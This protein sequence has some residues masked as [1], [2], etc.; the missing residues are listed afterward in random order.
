MKNFIICAVAVICIS[1]KNY[2]LFAQSGWFTVVTSGEI[3]KPFKDIFFSSAD[4]G[5]IFCGQSSEQTS[6]GGQTWVEVPN[7]IM[8]TYPGSSNS[9]QICFNI[10]DF[11]DS[12][13]RSTNNGESWHEYKVDSLFRNNY[14]TYFTFPSESI[15]FIGQG[16]YLF[17]TT[18]SAKTWE[19]NHTFGNNDGYVVLLNFRDAMHGICATYDVGSCAMFFDEYIWRTS[20]GGEHWVSTYKRLFAKD[21]FYQ[22]RF[23]R[24]IAN[25][26][27]GINFSYDDGETWQLIRFPKIVG[28]FEKLTFFNDTIGYA[29]TGA[30]LIYKTLD[31][32]STWFQQS[33]PPEFIK[34]QGLSRSLY[35][36]KAINQTICFAML[37]STVIKTIDG[38]GAVQSGVKSVTESSSTLLLRSN[39][40]SS[41]A[42]FAFESEKTPRWLEIFDLLGRVVYRETISNVLTSKEVD[43]HHLSCGIYLAKL[44][45]QSLRFIKN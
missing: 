38:G 10:G 13:G 30:G 23:S 8:K 19:R 22:E 43:M 7:P 26:Y 29:L 21:L 18:D 44:G 17:R 33:T 11:H 41:M 6:D 45:H 34:K 14:N 36:I 15:G 25:D 5:F 31:G 28:P 4:S 20:D 12:V 9:S 2:T 16:D 39:P 24:W 3:H 27:D 35:K 42:R 1:G 40:V 37:D 32:G